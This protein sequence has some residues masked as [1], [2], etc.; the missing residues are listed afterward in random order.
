[1]RLGLIPLLLSAALLS[2]AQ[3]YFIPEYDPLPQPCMPDVAAAPCKECVLGLGVER[4]AGNIYGIDVSHYQG[5]I[6]WDEVARDERVKFVYL[7]CTEGAKLQDNTYQRNLKECRR[8]G[9]PVGVYHFFSPTVSAF[10]QLMNFRNTSDPRV[11]TLLPIVD[12]ESVRS[13]NDSLV[14][15]TMDDEEV[16]EIESA[17]DRAVAFIRLWTK[18]EAAV[19]IQRQ[20]QGHQRQSGPLAPHQSP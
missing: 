18:K 8:L 2:G 14:R 3:D 12:V 13:Y 11:Q 17:E 1:M 4:S 9:I 16:R 19:H 7:K 5:Q 6:N 15:Y 20:H 10:E